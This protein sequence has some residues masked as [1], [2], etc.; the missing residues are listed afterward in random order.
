MLVS[1]QKPESK[2]QQDL[3]IR[4][5]LTAYLSDDE[6]KSWKGGLM[7][8]ERPGVSYPDG[9]FMDDGSIVVIYD[10]ERH[11]EGDILLARFT[12]ED[13][14]AGK[15]V[16]PNSFLKVTVSHTGGIKD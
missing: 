1:H 10:H 7:I 13:I 16:N 2:E 12:E 4:E 11:K 14:L 5:K 8:D 6:A 3:H 15:T 9:T